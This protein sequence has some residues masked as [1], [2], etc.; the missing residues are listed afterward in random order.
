MKKLM[1]ATILS[2]FTATS[3]SAAHACDGKNHAKS[4]TSTQA[5]KQ[6]GK[7]SDDATKTDQKTD[8]KS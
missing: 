1:L 4:E 5:K 6:D 7:K 3:F 2:A 8:Q